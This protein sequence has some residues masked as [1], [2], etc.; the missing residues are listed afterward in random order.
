LQK[1]AAKLK[2][3]VKRNKD[4]E[5]SGPM[6]AA[7]ENMARMYTEKQ[8]N[9]ASIAKMCGCSEKMMQKYPPADAQDFARKLLEGF[10]SEENLSGAG[11]AGAKATAMAASAE[12]VAPPRPSMLQAAAGKLKPA[13][14]NESKQQ[15]AMG[16]AIEGIARLWND[17]DGDAD[18]IA[19]VCGCDAALIRKFPPADAQEFAKQLFAGKYTRD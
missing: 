4:A 2:A 19:A 5:L 14:A 18:R 13:A 1:A 15:V 8:G 12:E 11:P 16:A 7:I 10:Y 6:K 17:N 3:T 9:P